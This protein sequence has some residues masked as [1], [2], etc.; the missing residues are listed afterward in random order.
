MAKY[1]DRLFARYSLFT[2]EN[3]PLAKY[4][5]RFLARYSL[6]T[7]ENIPYDDCLLRHLHSH[8][9]VAVFDIDEFLIP[10]KPF[11]SIAAMIDR[12]KIDW[13]EARN[14]KC[15]FDEGV[16]KKLQDVNNG[17]SDKQKVDL[18]DAA[19]SAGDR[20]SLPTTYAAQCTYFFNDLADNHTH[21]HMLDHVTRSVK[22]NPPAVY[23]KVSLYKFHVIIFF[24]YSRR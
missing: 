23:S 21:L 19:I 2:L 14:Q 22:F 15:K 20:C 8:R 11:P 12:A 24:L 4:P 10:A 5:D 7:L 6:F 9:Y 3:P 13:F 17:L 1:P 16:Y 18:I